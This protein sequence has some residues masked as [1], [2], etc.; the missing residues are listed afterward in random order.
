MALGGA[1]DEAASPR[2]QERLASSWF[3]HADAL[4][5]ALQARMNDRMAGLMRFLQDR[6]VKEA[7]DSEAILTELRK[8]ILAELDEPEIQQLALFTTA[9]QDQ[10]QR[11]VDALRARADEIP[12]EIER[13]RRAIEA[14]YAEPTAHLFPVAVTYLI[15][16]SI[17]RREAL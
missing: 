10:F 17:A 7:R 16:A 13:E 12:A 2:T 5:S 14:R 4:Q 1:T 8:S 11:N 9:E 6:A 15:P 3:Q